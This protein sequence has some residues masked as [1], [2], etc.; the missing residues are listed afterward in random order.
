MWYTFCKKERAMYQQ[1]PPQYQQPEPRDNTYKILA[2]IFF[3]I[4]F[5]LHILGLVPLI[6]VLFGLAGLACDVLGFVFLLLI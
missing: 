4:G 3:V 2:I 1:Y 5:F 6:G